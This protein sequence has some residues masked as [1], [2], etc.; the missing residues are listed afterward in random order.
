MISQ[1]AALKTELVFIKVLLGYAVGPGLLLIV[2]L[3]GSLL[4][5]ER[6]LPSPWHTGQEFWETIWRSPIVSAQSGD[7]TGGLM[8]HVVS[9]A[10]RFVIGTLCGTLS[11]LLLALGSIQLPYLRQFAMALV[12]PWRVIPPLMLVPIVLVA[13]APDNTVYMVAVA[14]YSFVSFLPNAMHALDQT[15]PVH[16]ELAK[17]AG[18][19]ASW[20]LWRVRLPAAAPQLLGPL[21][22]VCA[23]S[24]G[25]VIILEYVA[26]PSGLGRIMKFA[27]GY[28]AVDLLLVCILWTVI[29][30][31]AIDRVIDQALRRFTRWSSRV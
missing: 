30:G 23:F 22:N 12:L 15:R 7:P 8:P 9:T 2:W 29:I 5:G 25:I 28:S 14:A 26:A 21:K 17:T 19:S 20:I 11:A 31:S 3:A 16:L 1:S 6:W 10:S 13:S 24:L 4:I 18:A 27:L